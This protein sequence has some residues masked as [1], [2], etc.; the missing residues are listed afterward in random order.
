VDGDLFSR[1]RRDC[2]RLIEGQFRETSPARNRCNCFGWVVQ[3]EER[4]WYPRGE[5]DRSFWPDGVRDDFTVEAYATRGFSPCE[6]G[7]METDLEKIALYVDEDG[8]PSHAALQLHD[9][10]W[11]SK[12]GTWEDI[13]HPDTAC[14]EGGTYGVVALY[15]QRSRRRENVLPILP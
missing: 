4:P 5:P 9:G 11:S 1:L 8:E 10:R 13:E 15:L 3:D 14:L 2:P 7:D 6:N 12:M